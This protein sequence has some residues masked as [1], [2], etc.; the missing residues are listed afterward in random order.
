MENYVTFV[1]ISYYFVSLAIG[2]LFED[3]MKVFYLCVATATYVDNELVVMALASLSLVVHLIFKVWPN[4]INIS[5]YA[6]SDEKKWK[7]LWM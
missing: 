2:I 4:E 1:R 5:M 6:A 3:D 7:R